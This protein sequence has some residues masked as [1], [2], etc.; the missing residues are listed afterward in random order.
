ML[1]LMC[2]VVKM[3]KLHEIESAAK[4]GKIVTHSRSMHVVLLAACMPQ[5]HT[6]AHQQRYAPQFEG[7]AVAADL[8]ACGEMPL[9]QNTQ[10]QERAKYLGE[11]CTTIAYCPAI[12]TRCLAVTFIQRS[13]FNTYLKIPNDMYGTHYGV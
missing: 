7:L 1:N 10:L 11:P 13:H 9:M 3:D 5:T 4:P 8:E 6:L 2:E 12:A